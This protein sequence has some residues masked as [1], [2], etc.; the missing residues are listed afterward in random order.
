MQ[1]KFTVI[2][3]ETERVLPQALEYIHEQLAA[4]KL[5]GKDINRAEL[6]CE[7]VMASL[8]TYETAEAK[9]PHRL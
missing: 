9:T 5:T 2:T 3:N 1:K 7:E 8:L 4:L 6:M